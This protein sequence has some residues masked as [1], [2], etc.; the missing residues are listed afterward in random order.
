[1][2]RHERLTDEIREQAI[3]HALGI[4]EP[5][6]ARA[7]Q[8]HLQEGCAVCESELRA[9]E[10][11]ASQLPMAL[12]ETRP[13]PAVREKLLAR[14]KPKPDLP[15]FLHVVRSA[16]GAW[17]PTGVEGVS[18]KQL[19]VDPAREE[20]TMLVRMAPGA[21][22]PAHRH[23]GIEHCLVLEGDL[24]A[25]D[26]VLRAGDYQCNAAESLHQVTSTEQGCLLLVIASQH[27]ELLA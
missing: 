11:T 7:F 21:S 27:N 18:L 25:G 13:R 3:L 20:I 2:M 22:Y 23:A 9:F 24:R 6:Q 19:Y 4:L 15:A 5:K 17:E 12:R 10:E 1:M 26:L 14:I 16:E 8:E